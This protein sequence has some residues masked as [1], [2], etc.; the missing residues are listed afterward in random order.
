MEGASI[1]LVEP[2]EVSVIEERELLR[3]ERAEEFLDLL[4]QLTG[5]SAVQPEANGET[6]TPV[7]G[8]AKT[9][10]PRLPRDTLASLLSILDDY[11]EQ[12]YLLDPY[13]DR[14]VSHPVAALQRHI[15]AASSA[16]SSTHVLDTETVQSLSKLIYTYT[17]LRGYKTI[18]NFFPHEVVD[19]PAT[20]AYLEALESESSEQLQPNA[21]D[22]T[23]L[24]QCWELRYV[25]LLWLSLICMIPFDLEKFD[26]HRNDKIS[27]VAYR[28]EAVGLAFL[29]RSGKERDAAAVLL[30]KLFQREDIHS[31][32]FHA[33][34]DFS[35][36][37]LASDQINPFAATG[38]LQA[39]CEVVKIR[40]PAFVK[41][42]LAALNGILAIYDDADKAQLTNNGLI[43]KYQIKLAARLGLK[44]LRPRSRAL[45][46]HIKTLGSSE[47]TIAPM[48]DNEE[49]EDDS[50]VPE[51]IDYCIARLI[52]GLQHKDTVVRYSAA[53]GLARLCDRLPRS[54]ISQV[55]D[56]VVGLFHIN[57]PDLYEGA[58]DLS[59]VSEN[60]WQGACMA[61]AELARRGMLFADDLSDKLP[62]IEKALLFDIR[63]GAHSVGANVRD[64]ACYIVWAIARAHNPDV[65]RRHALSLAN[66][67]V[68]V[69]TLDRDVSIRRAAS[70]AFQESVGRLD[71][72]PHGIDVIRLTDF[73]AVSTRR[74]AF[75]EC[76]VQVAKFEEYR[77]YLVD[78]LLNVTLIHWDLPM[79]RLGAK[80]IARIAVLDKQR[81]LPSVVAALGQR[82]TSVD[83]VVVHGALLGLA[84][85]CEECR[86]AKVADA[87]RPEQTVQQ[88]DAA[89]GM[90]EKVPSSVFHAMGAAMV[91]QAACQLIAAGISSSDPASPDD[92]CVWQ[93]VINLALNRPEEQVQAAAAE[94]CH[95]AS[96]VLN[97][98]PRIKSTLDGWHSF[99]IAQQ[100]SNALVLGAIDYVSHA[101]SFESAVEHLV[102]LVNNTP[103]TG[104]KA[105][106]S[107]IETR[108]NAFDSL[109]RAVMGLADDLR[110]I[111][112]QELMGRV[113]RT[114]L[115]G[116]DDY[117]TDQRGDVG[118]WVRLSC[119]AGIRDILTLVHSKSVLTWIDPGLFQSLI[120]G[121]WKQTAE[122]IDH[123]RQTAG[124]SLMSLYQT[125]QLLS[126]TTPAPLGYE[127]VQNS[128]GK[129]AL[130]G[131]KT[132]IS[133]P[134]QLNGLDKDPAAIFNFKDA[135]LTFPRVAEMLRIDVYR[136]A[137][138][139]GIVVSVGSKS[140]LG[141]RI[142]GPALVDFLTAQH[143]LQAEA[144]ADE[145][146]PST[147][148]YMVYDLFMDLF[149]LAKRNYGNNRIYIPALQTVNLVLENGG[150]E[151]IDAGEPVAT[152]IQ[153]RSFDVLI[154]LLKMAST[155]INK[156]KN[157]QRVNSAGTLAANLVVIGFVDARHKPFV[158]NAIHT[159]LAH[160]FPTT[161]A[162]TAEKLFTAIDNS[163]FGSTALEGNYYIELE[164]AILDTK[165]ATAP[166]DTI[167]SKAKRVIGF[168]THAPMLSPEP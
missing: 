60:T 85:I 54:F 144:A 39:L 133:G 156:A 89:F 99:S 93:K 113:L 126:Q 1:R 147:S 134:S 167:A 36:Q 157:I 16:S 34:I 137:I 129:L 49:D 115:H 75:L 154:R 40:D 111:C 71:L 77:A 67:L 112:T 123:V 51:D 23:G 116:L 55:C 18:T 100:Q 164:Y 97:L 165:W 119:I 102:A 24:S 72:F 151:L 120:G 9:S 61:L 83:S 57:V 31:D 66:K 19:L 138:L 46:T 56:A 76:A 21:S 145:T 22:K 45:Q 110:N 15:R 6:A 107:N 47:P 86:S 4:Q 109:A 14:I 65:I 136:K 166:P 17:K 59:S 105:Y 158:L 62:W 146:S 103:A 30:G 48:G 27:S 26:H 53:K 168:L 90:I 106:S 12:P 152:E 160:A 2:E 140:D 132:D 108:R 58:N 69:A 91:L 143:E 80:A 88:P 118:S 84:E 44:L 122:R 10:R 161:R 29:S 3:F 104:S 162:K 13:L 155:N 114:L 150:V 52:D 11:Q 42:H 81:L 64:S 74:N 125:F 163:H 5:P 124:S 130:S 43:L 68:A 20:L 141:D 73:Y 96:L 38:I 128:F 7:S 98:T 78:H 153:T 70:A 117:T 50:D 149:E 79:R 41:E 159:F 142:I 87:G 95:R 37:T 101:A 32:R 33:F 94:A 139:E 28:I 92:S 8:S 127:L 63:R 35:H 121:L 82:V 135:K 148:P 25:C 131:N